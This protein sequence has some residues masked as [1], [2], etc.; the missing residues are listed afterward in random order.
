MRGNNVL[1]VIFSNSQD[2]SLP[3]L[4]GNR[5]MASVPFGGRYRLIDFTL[6]GMVNAGI[7]KVGVITKSNYQSLM[8]HISTGKPWDLSRKHAGLF[9]LPPFGNS[10]T[11]K[12]RNKIEALNGIMQFIQ[13]S[14]EEYVILSDCNA[15]CNPDY[16]EMLQFHSASGADI[17]VVYKHGVVPKNISHSMVFNVGEDNRVSD[18]VI[19]P[20]LDG[21]LNYAVNIYVMSKALLERLIID[22]ASRSYTSFTTDILQR[23]QKN[24]RLMGYEIRSY[25]TVIDSM[26]KYFRTSMDLLKPEIRAQLFHKDSPIYTKIRDEMPT[27]YGM[28]SV[29]KNSLIADGCIIEGEVENCILFRGVSVGRGAVIKNSIVMQ[30]TYIGDKANLNNVITDKS[31]TIKPDTYLSGAITYPIYLGKGIMV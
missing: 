10:N 3:E 17:T 22:A 28:E 18:I 24:L 30:G 26:L 20:G 13:H 25:C 4:T 6:S 14:R 16:S 1:G 19:N 12:Y 21:E 7:C 27:R 29:V 2:E 5:T 8:D 11:G 23:G 31:V 9:L 15:V